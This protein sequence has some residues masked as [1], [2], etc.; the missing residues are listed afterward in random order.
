MKVLV[1][2]SNGFV[3]RNLIAHLKRLDE[4][5]IY[6]YDFDSA[7]I[8]LFNGLAQA[9]IIYHLAGVNRPKDSTEFETGNAQFT[10]KICAFLRKMGVPPKSCFPHPFRSD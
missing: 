7:E 3:G 10:H 8:E 6:P 9:D 2:G 5:T 4:L 1:T